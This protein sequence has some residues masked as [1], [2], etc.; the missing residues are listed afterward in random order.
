MGRKAKEVVM[1]IRW[2][3]WVSCLAGIALAVSPGAVIAALL[4]LGPT[5][6]WTACMI[7]VA[8]LVWR[9]VAGGRI[10]SNK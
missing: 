1:G 3:V 4:L 5:A 9:A 10:G 7:G 8:V 6:L 2:W